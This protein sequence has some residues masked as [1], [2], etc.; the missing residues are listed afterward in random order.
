MGPSLPILTS[1]KDL[2]HQLYPANG[3]TW[4]TFLLDSRRVLLLVNNRS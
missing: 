4:T 3:I 2:A 1:F